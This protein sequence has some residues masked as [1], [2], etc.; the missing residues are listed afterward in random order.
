[1][2]NEKADYAWLHGPT[3]TGD[4]GYAYT[5]YTSPELRFN[6]ALSDV[7][8]AEFAAPLA[9]VTTLRVTYVGADRLP[10]EHREWDRNLNSRVT[11]T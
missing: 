1:M 3:I 2:R 11:H 7:A 6:S 8:D 9:T 4:S 5:G 10:V